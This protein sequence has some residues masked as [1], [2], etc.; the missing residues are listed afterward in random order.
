[1]I[2]KNPA[3]MVSGV[4]EVFSELAS[5][6]AFV[7]RFDVSISKRLWATSVVRVEEA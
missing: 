4:L 3:H 7:Q 6:K 5:N 2:E 1:M